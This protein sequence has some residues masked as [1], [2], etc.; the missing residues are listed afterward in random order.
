MAK[1]RR[2]TRKRTATSGRAPVIRRRRTAA[3]PLVLRGAKDPDAAP[4]RLSSVAGVDADGSLVKV[5]VKGALLPAS[6]ATGALD[7]A[8]LA[9]DDIVEIE[10]REGQIIWLSGEDYRKRFAQPAAREARDGAPYVPDSI[11]LSRGTEASRGAVGWAIKSLKV[12]GVDLQGRTAVRLAEAFEQRKGLRRSGLGLFR[13]GTKTGT[14]E[15][16]PAVPGDLDPAKAML[17]FIHGTA[18]STWGSFGDL[19]SEPRAAELAAIAQHYEGRLYAFEHPTLTA[20]PIRNALDLVNALPRG[21]R[22]HLV[23]H[24]RGG[25][26]GEL[27]CR[28][29]LIA[30]DGARAD[31]PA[32]ALPP[33]TA[34]EKQDISAHAPYQARGADRSDPRSVEQLLEELDRALKQQ[35]VQVERFVRVACPALGT[36]LASKRLDRWLSVI[37]TVAGR[38]LPGSPL[39][40]VVGALGDFLAAVIK[41]RTDPTT[42][43]GIEAMMP[44]SPF[45]RLI[46]ATEGRVEGEL[47][48]IAGDIEPSSWWKKIAIWASDRFYS[49]D[50]DLVVNTPS[51][52]GGAKRQAGCALQKEF[53]GPTVN[54]FQYFQNAD[55]A[56]SVVAALRLDVES[57]AR[58][59]F[60]ALQP[61]AGRIARVPSPPGPRPIVFFLPGIMGSEL[62]VNGDTVWLNFFRLATG[63]FMQLRIGSAAVESGSPLK[64]SYG[65]LTEHLRA[66]HE[67]RA[68]AY[69]W[70]KPVETEARRF[71]SELKGALNDARRSRM[72]VRILAHSMGGLVARA[73]MSLDE[74]LWSEFRQQPGARLIMLGTPNGGSHAITE[75]LTA[76]S[77]TLSKLALLDI[78]HRETEFLQLIA[79]FPGVLAMLPT[80]GSD[81]YFAA[82]TWHRYH[83]SVPGGWVLPDVADLEV[84]SAFRR[85]IGQ[86]PIDPAVMIYVAGCARATLCNLTLIND[87]KGRARFRFEA[88]NRG[89]GRVTWASGMLP[90]LPTWYMDAEHG[91][92]AAREDAFAAL[93]E[94]LETGR[95]LRLSLTPPVA[96]DVEEKFEFERDAETLFPDE[97]SLL[98]EVMGSRRG[99]AVPERGIDTVTRVGVVHGDL[100]YARYPLAVGHYQDDAIVSAERALDVELGGELRRRFQL[101]LYPG[102]LGTSAVVINEKAQLHG[103]KQLPGA[104]IV[105]IGGAGNLSAAALT[106]GFGR[107]L[108]EYVLEWSERA[109]SRTGAEQ[110]GIGISSLLIGTGEGGISVSE[111]V[112][113]LLRGVIEANAAL[114]ST[115]VPARI[116]EVEF[117]ELWEDHALQA[118]RALGVLRG[119]AEFARAFNFAIELAA[120]RGGRARPSVSEPPGWWHR[121]QILG[122]PEPH[123]TQRFLRF[124][125][126]TR[127][128]RMEVRLHETQRTLVDELVNTAVKSTDHSPELSR[129]LFELLV[130]TELKA[131][132][133]NEDNLVLLLD[134]ESARYPWELLE[135]HSTVTSRREPEPLV[136]KRGLLRQ[137]AVSDHRPAPQPNASRGVLIIWDPLGPYQSLPGARAEAM[138]VRDEFKRA[139]FEAICSGERLS[140]R[141]VIEQLYARPYRV[142]HIAAHGVYRFPAPAREPSRNADGVDASLV[143]GVVMGKDMFLTALEVQQMRQVPELVFLNCCHLGRIEERVQDADS[144]HREAYHLIASSLAL[145]F[146]KMGVRAVVAAGWAVDD[147]VAT[148]FARTFYEKMLNGVTFGE[149]V[150]AARRTAYRDQEN[151]NTWGAYQ[152]YGDPDYRLV[153]EFDRRTDGT[154]APFPSLSAALY[155]I[156]NQR[157]ALQAI[158]GGDTQEELAAL[159]QVRQRLEQQ[160]WIGRPRVALS[161]AAAY[162]EALEYEPALRLYSRAI[163]ENLQSASVRD[164]E[165][166]ANLLGRSAVQAWKRRQGERDVQRC[167]A[168]VNE[169]KRWLAWLSDERSGGP[170]GERLSLL[171]HASKRLAWMSESMREALQHVRS[172]IESY[173][174][175][176]EWSKTRTGKLDPYP[177]LNA[178]FG[179]LVEQWASTGFTRRARTAAYDRERVAAVRAAL[180]ATREFDF[181]VDAGRIE[182]DLLEALDTDDESSWHTLADRYRAL[183]RL[184]SRLEFGSVVDQVDFLV[185]MAALAG[186]TVEERRL[187]ELLA[188]LTNGA[189]V[190]TPASVRGGRARGGE[191]RSRRKPKRA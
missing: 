101:G 98:R 86:A 107:A 63:A 62:R 67:V 150:K 20:S 93:T 156:G 40:D 169:A 5:A 104:L 118:M 121:L 14:W 116:S 135:D 159:A 115:S 42:L 46:N 72:P 49:G 103:P 53:R 45:I 56:R 30:T 170:T 102:P 100:A 166:Y 153:S 182:W 96:R 90:G 75:L 6:R 94:L 190:P 3:R 178:L 7:E 112:A 81:D 76:N 36:T 120:S 186:R 97:E 155:E 88:T 158:G 66:T 134:E 144:Q 44:E 57:L 15:L 141:E 189:S 23:S 167:R 92:L 105:G 58:D 1:P 21:A 157:A 161:L 37:G 60:E 149:A 59:G 175:A 18:S 154:V 16:T 111:A 127:R 117:I 165:Q 148:T 122:N 106:R 13:C 25:L 38:A 11:V 65:E 183:R 176:A 51:M 47:C 164:I 52:R 41:E 26:V 68:F 99:S 184:S 110:P 131:A 179:N 143:T 82:K 162:W 128:A 138:A 140:G 160:D 24:S 29:R 129:T 181:W 145:E 173:E 32:R 77:P 191:R 12:V 69:D 133:P 123:S 172:M 19:W 35:H 187:R 50:H 34:R 4:P 10:F 124:M 180:T 8:E 73:A 91:D 79:R 64:L 136:I 43:P 163:R 151:C 188:T 17:V 174:R 177:V 147:A 125:A 9:D 78:G 48:A 185:R 22:V 89:D 132:A 137:L 85:R 95:T 171:G 61:P 142:L 109:P 152:C 83:E 31:S 108:L 113:A 70:R 168:Q 55:S 2:G 139:S 71:A 84:A 87:E 80:E 33:F 114:A 74:G 119:D 130:P 39:I 28:A 146:I 54:H 126:L 27:L